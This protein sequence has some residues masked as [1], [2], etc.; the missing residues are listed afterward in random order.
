[1]KSANTKIRAI[2]ITTHKTDWVKNNLTSLHIEKKK[3]IKKVK[4]EK[5]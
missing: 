1:M 4:S 3:L 2:P 5:A